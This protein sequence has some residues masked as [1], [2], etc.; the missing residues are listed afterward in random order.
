[1]SIN[2]PQPGLRAALQRTA[3][4]SDKKY[5][6]IRLTVKSMLSMTMQARES[7]G[8]AA[9]AALP[10]YSR[11]VADLPRE[12]VVMLARAAARPL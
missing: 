11:L 1:V 4:L 12:D 6:G 7:L 2:P 10:E 3:I 5:R 8:F 9:T